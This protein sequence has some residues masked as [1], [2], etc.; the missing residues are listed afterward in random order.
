MEKNS[1]PLGLGMALVQ[2]ERAMKQFEALNDQQ[3]QT[4]INKA[5]KINSK[6]E[7]QGFVS[8]LSEGNLHF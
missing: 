4:V 1:L 5:R 6:E 3:K 2:N 8:Y 7:M